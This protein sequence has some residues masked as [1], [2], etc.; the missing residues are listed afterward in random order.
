MEYP[1]V[2]G[3]DNLVPE[4]KVLQKWTGKWTLIICMMQ[5]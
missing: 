1:C 4:E 5:L 2:M 3:I